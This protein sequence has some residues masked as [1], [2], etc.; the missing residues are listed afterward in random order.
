MKDIQHSG[1]RKSGAIWLWLLVGAVCFGVVFGLYY[2]LFKP[3]VA[4]LFTSYQPYALSACLVAAAVGFYLHVRR[5]ASQTD[6]DK[7]ND[8]ENAKWEDLERIKSYKEFH[9]T[10]FNEI[11]KLSSGVLI[12]AQ[13]TKKDIDV[14]LYEPNHTLIVGTTG[15]GKTTGYIDQ[16]VAILAKTSDKPS[17]VITDPKGEL[18]LRHANT[19]ES[20]GYKI[21]TLDLREP[22][23]SERWNPF[24]PIV[25]R[26]KRLR[27]YENDLKLENG[28]Y[29]VGD[30]S[31]SSL[32]ELQAT[33][34]ELKD[35]LYERAR[36]LIYTLCPISSKNEP[37]WEKGARDLL[38]GFVMAMAEDAIDG[39]I[40]DEQLQLY[41]I[42][43]NITNYMSEDCEELKEY[44]L[45]RGK[46]SK[47]TSLVNTVLISQDKTLSSF[48]SSVSQ[49]MN[50]ILAD[51]AIMAMTSE[52]EIDISDID[53]QPTAVFIIFPD[54]KSHR[55]SF[56]TLFVSQMYKE[57]VAK[58]F[59]NEKKGF[60][61]KLKRKVY[62]LMDEF[63]NLPSFEGF[64]NMITV[65]RSRGIFFTLVLQAYSQ[66]INKYGKE[67]ADVIKSNCNVK[68]FIGTDDS[69]TRK[70]FS[71]LMGN[72][73]V[74]TQSF[75]TNTDNITNISGNATVTS[76]P[77]ISPSELERL[78]GED[79]GNAI[80]SVRGYYGI[81]SHFTPSYQLKE[82]YCPSGDY[83]KAD[84]PFKSFDK[85]SI[86]FDITGRAEKLIY[87]EKALAVIDE[88]VE[89]E[90]EARIAAEND[91]I[92]ELDSEY[93]RELGELE[94][95]LNGLGDTL[96][97]DEL[98][99]LKNTPLADKPQLLMK[100]AQKEEYQGTL[101]LKLVS[102][103]KTAS[104][105]L[106]KIRKIYSQI[107]GGEA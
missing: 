41:N 56:I 72:R 34:M 39:K 38:F 61:G 85:D 5:G 75:S 31:F 53:N 98:D 91:F 6:L 69:E 40:K 93:E 17:L 20:N 11:D 42:Y 92:T 54:E 97:Q 29:Y 104:E 95:R 79:K 7:G 60:G 3:T 4:E 1:K 9:S 32:E 78:N 51:E 27:S 84:R 21:T 74:F 10:K 100:L 86:V 80:I 12:Q 82:K 65:A 106:I 48:M 63:G 62:M 96:T 50:T 14:L 49:Y 83:D 103:A 73:K 87:D 70:E 57:L 8:L 64:D 58:A 71:E 59:E 25:H 66:L 28:K 35:E 77:L 68:I 43:Y 23:K 67:L 18:L 89:S 99:E 36:D 13:K 88:L 26:V 30:E 44:L 2:L 19:L 45:N 33:V 52:N 94:E 24:S 81:W 46:Y 76:Q 15:T 55:H 22:F 102:A 16:T 37:T 47:V 90:S 101:Q 105:K 107:E